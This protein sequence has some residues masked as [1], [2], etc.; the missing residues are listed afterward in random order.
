MSEITFD[1]AQIGSV[2]LHYAKAGSGEKLVVLL[3]GFPEFWYSWRKQLVA[4]SD[5][6]TVVAPDLRGYNGRVRAEEMSGNGCGDD[7]GPP[8][9]RIPARSRRRGARAREHGLDRGRRETRFRGRG[10]CQAGRQ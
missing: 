10:A 5:E 3:H 1:Y 2:K 6:Y 8:P 4:L 9:P 7:N